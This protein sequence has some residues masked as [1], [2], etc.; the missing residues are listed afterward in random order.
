MDGFLKKAMIAAVA[1]TSLVIAGCASRSTPYQPIA[2]ANRI[3]GGYSDERL[4]EDRYRVS[5]AGNTLT[6]REKVESYLLFR[7]AELTLEQGRDWFAIEDRVVEHDIEREV[8]RDPLY[9]P[10]YGSYYGYWQPSWRYYG[11][12]GWRSWYPYYGHSFWT[13]H[14][15]IREVERFEAIAEIRLGDGITPNGTMRAFNARE[16]IDRIGPLVEYPGEQ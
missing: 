8:R 14:V 4:G 11:P 13:D 6:S 16:V 3:A 5:F 2:S 15:D 1:A 9:D 7:A 10:W 12:R